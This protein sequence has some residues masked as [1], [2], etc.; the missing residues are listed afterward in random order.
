MGN[1]FGHPA[2]QRLM[3]RLLVSLS[4]AVLT[5]AVAAQEPTPTKPPVAPK[6]SPKPASPKPT[7]PHAE[8]DRI[9]Q[10]HVRDGL[11]DYAGLRQRDEA[12]LRQYAAALGAIDPSK[13]EPRD[14]FAFFVNLYNANML[15]AVLDATAKDP[16]WTP[17]AKDFAVFKEARVLLQGSKVTLDHVEHEV[18][19]KTFQDFR[20]HVAL[21]CGARSCPPLRANAYEGSDLESVLD[22]NFAA[23]LH[24]PERNQVDK[25]NKKVRLSK[26]FEWFATDFGGE[27]GIRK[28]LGKHLGAEAAGYRIEYLDYSWQLNARP[29]AK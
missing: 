19:R 10:Q 26:L 9:L 28:L 4:L 29:V 23:F 24:D 17:A 25:A 13:L 18:L 8:F 2:Y 5:A 21:V 7:S 6:E 16:K 22:A 14:K 20:V 11:V 15:L 12:A 3:S 27:A 1:E